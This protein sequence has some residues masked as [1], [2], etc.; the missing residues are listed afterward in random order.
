MENELLGKLAKKYSKT[1][2]QVALRWALQNNFV[3]LPKSKTEKY[4]KENIDIY[5]FELTKEELDEV[6]KLNKNYH[7]CWDPN[8]IKY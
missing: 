2:S 7:T 1:V 5:G 8:S 3:I 4:I 6:G